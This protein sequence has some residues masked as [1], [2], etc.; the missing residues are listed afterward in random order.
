MM[1]DTQG[2]TAAIYS[3][4]VTDT[5]GFV[6][7][8]IQPPES[9][10]TCEVGTCCW[11]RAAGAS[12]QM[13]R[14]GMKVSTLAQSSA[15]TL[16]FCI[17]SWNNWNASDV[18]DVYTQAST[19]RHRPFDWIGFDWIRFDSY[20]ESEATSAILWSDP[21]ESGHDRCEL[22]QEERLS[23][24]VRGA[25]IIRRCQEPTRPYHT[26]CERSGAEPY[27]VSPSRRVRDSRTPWHCQA[28]QPTRRRS[29]GCSRKPL[30]C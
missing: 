9:K 28:T 27:V 21:R 4:D 1:Y 26:H 10:A 18:V 19:I 7:F 15:F 14:G 24:Q 2:R 8:V 6:R 30:R 5:A 3:I 16:S 25:N 17:S 22:R 13:L 29:F 20:V 23:R 11:I 12:L